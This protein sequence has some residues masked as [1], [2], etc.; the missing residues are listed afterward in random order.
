MSTK[1]CAYVTEYPFRRLTANL[2]PEV[3]EPSYTLLVA[4]SPNSRVDSV[5]FPSKLKG[6]FH[7]NSSTLGKG[8]L[9]LLFFIEGG[10][11]AMDLDYI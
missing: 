6:L 10:S 5:I 11:I 1:V 7:E 9:I 4:P 3:L 2:L 8:T